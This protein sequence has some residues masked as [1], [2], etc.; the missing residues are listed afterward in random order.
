MA[1]GE[2]NTAMDWTD[3]FFLSI[4]HRLRH[5][6]VLFCV[7]GCSRN[8][9]RCDGPLCCFCSNPQ[10]SYISLETNPTIRFSSDYNKRP[11][12]PSPPPLSRLDKSTKC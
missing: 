11:P 10:L 2:H 7:P 3:R 8:L 6:H 12:S 5:F 4:E 1:T 9:A